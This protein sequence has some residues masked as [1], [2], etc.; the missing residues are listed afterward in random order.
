MIFDNFQT[1]FWNFSK[2]FFDLHLHLY[3]ILVILVPILFYN[4]SL[5]T[6]CRTPAVAINEDKAKLIWHPKITFL[7]LLS[8]EKF[9]GVGYETIKNFY[10]RANSEKIHTFEIFKLKFSCD[11]DFKT[12]P[13]D[14]HECD[15]AFIDWRF[16]SKEMIFN[17][18]KNI[19]Y[20]DQHLTFGNKGAL[21]LSTSKTPFEINITI[22]DAVTKNFGKFLYSITGIKLNLHRKSISLL[23][24][25]YYVPTGMFAI[26]SMAS[27][28]IHPDVVS[29]FKHFLTNSNA[30]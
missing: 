10:Y 17:N 6:N 21:I 22:N 5:P 29:Y 15:L 19:R 28:V 20:G 24:G 7:N 3:L 9:P 13:F 4:I 14:K 25:S 30:R 18:T 11:F 2:I 8:L 27:F 23:Y 16:V 26:L 12:Y 1:P